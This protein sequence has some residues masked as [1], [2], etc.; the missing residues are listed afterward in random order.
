MANN[1]KQNELTTRQKRAIT[2]LLVAPDRK[3]A[4]E[5]AK[6]GYRS[7]NR[8]LAEDPY[9]VSQLNQ[10]ETLMIADQVR[11][12]VRDMGDNRETMR[13]IRDSERNSAADRL[14]A[15]KYLDDSLQRWR[16]YLNL[17]TRIAELEALIYD[18]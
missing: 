3:A 11:A 2:A 15:A 5:A 7:I 1:G 4:A 18:N 14:R 12:L 13:T 8:W 10:A 9:F 16:D 17:E 6:V